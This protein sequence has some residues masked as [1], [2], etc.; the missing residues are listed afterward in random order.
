MPGSCP[1]GPL[2]PPAQQIA[3]PPGPAGPKG[4]P[5]PKGDSATITEQHLATITD[6]IWK[7]ITENP[8]KFRG[9]KG[10]RGARG[11]AAPPI[12]PAELA[13]SLPPITITVRDSQGRESSATKPLGGHFK[14]TISQEGGQAVD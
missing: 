8:D 4:E 12:D 1:P 3:G 10:E 5:G 2:T 6:E 14:I 9:A 7:R 11:E 13:K